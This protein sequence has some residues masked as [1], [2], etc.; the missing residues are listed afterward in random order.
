MKLTTKDYID[1][2]GEEGKKKGKYGVTVPKPFN[3]DMREKTRT[4][5]IREKKV[6]EM[7]AEKKIAE[8][9]ILKHQ[10]RHN[11]IPP[12]VLIP[13]Y[14]TIIEG[15]EMRRLEVKKNSIAITKMKERPFSFYERDKNKQNPDP[16]DYLPRDL[17]KGSFRANPIPRACS[18]LIFD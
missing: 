3:F 11:P 12:E 16:E 10:F 7:V 15:N 1:H 6:E 14:R 18:V 9:N 8:E 13:R 2:E 4:K 5:T 17:K